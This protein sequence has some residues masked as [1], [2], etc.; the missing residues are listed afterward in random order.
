MSGTGGGESVAP[1][2][3]AGSGPA[4]TTTR[5][6]S[7]V[8]ADT[9]AHDQAGRGTG[10]PK[11][12]RAPLTAAVVAAVALPL[13]IASVVA[14]FRTGY[15]ASDQAVIELRVRD[16]G[17]A[18]TPL[19]GP[20]SRY[21]WN[22]PGPLMFWVL[23]PLW[24]ALGAGVGA[25]A[26][27][28]GLLNAAG[29]AAGLMVAQRLG[30]SALLVITGVAAA[31]LTFAS[32]TDLLD[33]WNP[34]LTVVPTVVFIV[35]AA[36]IANGDDAVVPVAVLA[37]SLLVQSHVG[38]S[39]LVAALGIWASVRLVMALIRR[40]QRADGTGR[41]RLRRR[42]ALV[43]AVTF[44]LTVVMWSAP[45]VE[46]FTS[47]PGN[48]SELVTHFTSADEP[49]IGLG[50]AGDAAGRYLAPWGPWLGGTEP[51]NPF[52][53][54]I[55]PAPWWWAL[56]A[57]AGLAAGAV[58]AWRRRDSQVLALSGVVAVAVVA[59]VVAT[60]RI[61]GEPF[62]YLLR[63]WWPVAAMTWVAVAWSLVRVVPGEVRTRVRPAALAV[64][65]VVLLMAATVNTVVLVRTPEP[66]P[67]EAAVTAVADEVVAGLA[68]GATYRVVP[69]GATG[70][71]VMMGVVNRMDAGRVG[72]IAD[73]SLE[74]SVGPRRVPGGPG[75]PGTV[76]G[77]IVVASGDAIDEVLTRPGVQ[78]LA[79]WNPLDDT[80]RRELEMLQRRA[81]SA[82]AAAGR[83][84]LVGAERIGTL[85]VFLDIDP[86][87]ASELDFPAADAARITELVR[88]G[89]PVVVIL[90]PS[91]TDP[92]SRPDT[93]A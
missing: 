2:P 83:T 10:D 21:G 51:A 48:L 86:D 45:L 70:L 62:L 1:R 58:L 24:R 5:T 35:A 19:V 69:V 80:E 64:A 34:W 63:F 22:H 90:D 40:W 75:A 36:A 66:S 60:T 30:G 15:V 7:P 89:E 61:T 39:V 47:D 92:R 71:E 25:M 73:P 76:S 43:G 4:A 44:G 81:A 3:A 87:L 6:T 91:V 55:E 14:A 37:G 26:A 17:S 72:V 57:L 54:A 85:E 68:P 82:L 18:D 20:F 56:P 59:S 52:S 79:T 77:E 23:A 93:G 42:W 46:H 9:P 31:L 78:V 8:D 27:A 67:A 53:G 13:L 28:A 41:A 65:A 32:G 88:R 33:A 84:E 29:L 12:W 11:G 16:V 50:T 38:Y 74:T 49:P